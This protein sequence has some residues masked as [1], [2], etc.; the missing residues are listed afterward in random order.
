MSNSIL[1]YGEVLWDL[2]P[3]GP[4]LGGGPLNFG[5]RLSSLGDPVIMVSRLGRD[6]LGERAAHE[7]RALGMDAGFLQWDDTRPTGTVPVELDSQGHPR[8]T[9]LPDVAYDEIETTP[10]LLALAARARCICF[11]TLIQRSARSRD[12]LTNIMQAA[13]SAFKALDINLRKDCYSADTIERSLTL[14]DAL[15][16]ND[17]EIL[18]LAGPAGL[19]TEPRE[20]VRAALDRWSLQVCVVTLG[21]RGACGASSDGQ[22]ADAAGRPAQI[23][24]TVG[25]GDAFTA[26]LIH[27]WLGGQTLAQ[28]LELGNVMGALTAGRRGGTAPISRH[29]IELELGHD[30]T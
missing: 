9:I 10:N 23:V 28:A 24:D 19:P 8:F 30:L 4:A 29:E 22:I 2:L 13:P 25:A 14:A 11:G 3:A 18:A 12:T 27:A 1:A 16:L 26:G 17:D 6:D 21:A 7:I 20:F 5:Y 15:K